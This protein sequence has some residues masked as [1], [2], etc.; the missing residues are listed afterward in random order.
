MFIAS[1][2]R[3]LVV[4]LILFEIEFMVNLACRR[5]H[6]RVLRHFRLPITFYCKQELTKNN[7][8]KW[9][10]RYDQCQRRV[11]DK[12]KDSSV[13]SQLRFSLVSYRSDD[14][15]RDSWHTDCHRRCRH[16]LDSQ[17]RLACA[18]DIYRIKRAT[19]DKATNF[20]LPP[21]DKGKTF[22]ATVS[23]TATGFAL[24]SSIYTKRKITFNFDSSAVCH[25][26]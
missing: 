11:A 6:R 26:N 12:C 20:T 16:E 4:G 25:I 18:K 19:D 15:W 9:R 10:V 17:I 14:Q 2:I 22:D 7:L 8:R 5:F 13:I 1:E 21:L 3:E 23:S 24:H